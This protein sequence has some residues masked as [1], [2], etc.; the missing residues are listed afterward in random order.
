[1]PVGQEVTQ[2]PLCKAADD[3]QDTHLVGVS[4]QVAHTEA[5]GSQVFDVELPIDMF[6]GHV[7]THE[8][9]Y[10]YL[11]VMQ[12][13][14]A[15]WVVQVTQGLTH[16]THRVGLWFVSGYI[17]ESQFAKHVPDVVVLFKKGNPEVLLQLEQLVLILTHVPQ[18]TL[19]ALHCSKVES[20]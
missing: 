11:P 6:T 1:M 3:A 15:V 20:G 17:P 10:R 16:T 8:V 12:D 14:Q 19:Q 9:K 4:T 13:K 7:V 2:E 18:I 5:H